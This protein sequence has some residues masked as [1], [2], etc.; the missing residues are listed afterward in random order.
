MKPGLRGQSPQYKC[1][2]DIKAHCRDL[3]VFEGQKE[4]KE[5]LL[6]NMNKEIDPENSLRHKC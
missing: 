5:I 3:P 2:L 1:E 6:E 4:P